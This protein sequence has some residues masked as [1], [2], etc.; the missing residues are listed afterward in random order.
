MLALEKVGFTMKD[1]MF[2]HVI[3][4]STMIF[5]HTLDPSDELFHHVV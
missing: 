4:S 3:I 1:F 2:H 5:V